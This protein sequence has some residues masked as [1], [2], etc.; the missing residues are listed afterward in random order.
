MKTI[1]QPSATTLLTAEELLRLDAQGV[2][3][4]LV[5][6]L[7][8]KMA[9]AG[10]RHGMVAMRLGARLVDH[11]EARGLGTVIGTDAGILLERNPDTVREPDIAFTSAE[12][13]PFGT[14]PNGYSGVVPDLVV[15]VASPNDRPSELAERT[16]MWLSFGVRLLWVVH[17]DA[18][19]I[20]VH[21][22]GTD[23]AAAQQVETLTLDDDLDGGSV[24][25]GFTY[26][27]S[28]LFAA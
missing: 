21:R 23:R 27:L 28:S 15:E 7:F 1:T 6:G 13:L 2:R 9:P 18:N 17:P 26:S 11:A 4:E 16:A 12:R 5:R 24:L 8:C 3:G 10:Y 22:A 14:E 19:T 20:E 25:P